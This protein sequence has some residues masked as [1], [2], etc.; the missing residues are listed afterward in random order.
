VRSVCS[1]NSLE[2]TDGSPADAPGDDVVGV[3]DALE[4][5]AV[6]LAAAAG[7]GMEVVA[8]GGRESV[9]R[10]DGDDFH[11]PTAGANARP[12]AATESAYSKVP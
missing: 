10:V 2:K 1:L 11:A 3:P 7:A 5:R 9:P 6:V 4:S 8:L 12:G